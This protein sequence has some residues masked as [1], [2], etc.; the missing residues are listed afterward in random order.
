MLQVLQSHLRLHLSD[1]PSVTVTISSVVS[2][3]PRVL[4]TDF[5][6]QALRILCGTPAY[7]WG[8]R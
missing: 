7:R 1:Q 3:Q 2:A 8:L 4:R 6:N 5:L